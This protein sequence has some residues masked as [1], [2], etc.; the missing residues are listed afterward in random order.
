MLLKNA[1]QS[2]Y[3]VAQLFQGR[4]ELIFT[5]TGQEQRLTSD[6]YLSDGNWHS[7]SVTVISFFTATLLYACTFD[8]A[9]HESLDGC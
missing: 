3:F 5:H 2:A 1:N 9:F 8:N 7:V 4:V 6:S